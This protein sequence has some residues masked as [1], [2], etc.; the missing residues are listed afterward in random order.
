M[1]NIFLRLP[2]PA[3]KASS[4]LLLCVRVAASS[5]TLAFWETSV[6][7]ALR[8]RG[9]SPAGIR[10]LCRGK[11]LGLGS[12]TLKE[13]GISH[14]STIDIGGS[15]PSQGFSR[16]HQLMEHLLEMLCPVVPPGGSPPAADDGTSSSR[17]PIMH[18]I[19][20]EVKRCSARLSA[21]AWADPERRCC[22]CMSCT[23][24]PNSTMWICGALLHSSD[25][26]VVN[27]TFKVVQLLLH[28]R[29]E[30]PAP[31]IYFG[32]ECGAL[33]L[34]AREADFGWLLETVHSALT[35]EGVAI[36][37]LLSQRLSYDAKTHPLLWQHPSKKQTLLELAAR[38]NFP[39][40]LR[41]LLPALNVNRLAG[42][43]ARSAGA[44]ACPPHIFAAFPR[45]AAIP[46]SPPGS[47]TRTRGAASPLRCALAH[48]ALSTPPCA[49]PTLKTSSALSRR[50]SHHGL[51]FLAL[52]SLSLTSCFSRSVVPR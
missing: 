39:G 7:P 18:A 31:L 22:S 49:S 26:A 13:A 25:A 14:L 16:L 30:C 48:I 52:R 10:L 42:S 21:A 45:A 11:R 28:A 17:E 3:S 35:P 36:A 6:E 29:T 51:A 50:H 43:G 34:G 24:R 46:L 37:S 41:S 5:T 12:A 33:T 32:E 23:Q 1:L 15:L 44:P 4:P 20:A 19:D 38:S 40:L 47:I 2:I 27:L 9:I 8:K